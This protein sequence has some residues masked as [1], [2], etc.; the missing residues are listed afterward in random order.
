MSESVPSPAGGALRLGVRGKVI[1][2]LLATLFVALAASSLLALREQ[3]RYVL[4]ETQQ[5]GRETAHFIA[6][7]LA[8]SVI[9]YDYH[10]LEL[11]LQDLIRG[12]D[13]VYARVENN[14][15]NVMAVAGALPTGSANNQ[16]FNEDIRLNDEL[17]GRLYLSMSTERILGALQV[18]QR[19][20]LLGQGIAIV[21]VLL[22]GFLALS[23]LIIRPLTSM[24]RVIR[25]SLKAGN[26][27][28]ERIPSNA[29]D[30]FG[31]LAHG[32][33]ALGGQL[34]EARGKLESRIQSANQELRSAYEQLS[35]QT[36]EL[37][38]MNRELE[39]LSITDP[40]TGLYNRRYFEKLMDNEVAQSIRQ[41]ETISI[42]LLNVDHLRM[43]NEQHG[44]SIGD[45]ILRHV[46]DTILSRLR[47]TDVACRYGGNQFF[48]LCR[49]ATISSA[50]AFA[51]DLL[52]ALSE[53]RFSHQDR[54][55]ELSINIGAATIPGVH[56]V[57]TT[58]Q[59]LRCAEEAL[60]HCKLNERNGV[61]HYSML[62]REVRTAS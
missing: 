3:E 19:D 49:R 26:A 2:V 17:L 32:F 48:I 28:L 44:H 54:D 16:D 9:S 61:A 10:T 50:V 11:I 25:R 6:Q 52:R 22:A 13:I 58:E 39:Q 1:L 42:L 62:D 59:F 12:R 51:D 27:R 38:E 24:S 30:E 5:R 15:G 41:D 23:V 55:L 36:R 46:A 57:S 29:Q 21:V 43:L 4:E 8:Y 31:E 47:L 33:N 34:D 35:A 18:R 7:Y 37:R 14:R 56:N 60:R 40:L 20:A 53:R 45:K